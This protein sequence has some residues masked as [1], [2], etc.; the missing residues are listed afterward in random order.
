MVGAGGLRKSKKSQVPELELELK[1]ATERN[2]ALSE[3]L[4]TAH[5]DQANVVEDGDA[6]DTPEPGNVE[7]L[8]T[9]GDA[10]VIEKKQNVA[11]SSSAFSCSVQ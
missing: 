8:T 9:D 2:P 1:V 11:D 6:L 5:T 7:P 10:S 3:E 4:S